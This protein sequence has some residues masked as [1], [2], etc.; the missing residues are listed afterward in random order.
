MKK[1][2]LVIIIV[3]IAVLA[4]IFLSAGQVDNAINSAF[5]PVDKSC[6]AD[7]DCA[8]TD[9]DCTSPCDGYVANKNWKPLCLIPYERPM[10]PCMVRVPGELKCIN[11]MCDYVA[12]STAF[13]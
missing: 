2:E 4:I 6:N 7:S 5:N 11:Y 8:F 9:L 10:P 12:N 1:Q 3:F 13:G